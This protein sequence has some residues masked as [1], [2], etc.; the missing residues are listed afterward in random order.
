LL[1]HCI[2]SGKT[3]ETQALAVLASRQERGRGTQ[4]RTWEGPQGNVYLT[5]ALP[6]KQ[7][8]VTIT[9]LPLQVGILVAKLLQTFLSPLSSSSSSS[10]RRRR[11][12]QAI[13]VNVK[14]PNDVLVNQRKIAGVLIENWMPPQEV[15]TTTSSG[16]WL[17]I[18]VGIN[19]AVAPTLPPG[20]RPSTCLQDYYENNS[21]TTN[22]NNSLPESAVK[23]LGTTLSRDLIDWIM[24]KDDKNEAALESQVLKDWRSLAEFGQGYK[25]RDTGEEV[26]VLDIQSDGQ[27]KVRGANGSRKI[28]GSRLL[29]LSNSHSRK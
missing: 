27:L 21:G 23:D 15:S 28:P 3:D 29:V 6:M 25:I 22:S 24:T 14:W 11:Q 12:Q 7:I 17:L 1:S 16:S 4:G 26:I 19:V 2:I 18:G 20:I 13:T 10:V 5:V 8:P 9:L